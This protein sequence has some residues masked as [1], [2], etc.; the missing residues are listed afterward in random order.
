MRGVGLVLVDAG[1]VPH[2][3]VGIEDLKTCRERH[4]ENVVKAPPGECGEAVDIRGDPI[5]LRYCFPGVLVLSLGCIGFVRAARYS[6][7][8]FSMDEEKGKSSSWWLK[9]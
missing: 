4:S 9:C 1:D 3:A 8:L 6:L 5:R 2:E 7:M